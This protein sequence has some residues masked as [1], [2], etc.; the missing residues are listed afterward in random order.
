MW[1]W[2]ICNVQVEM[3]LQFFQLNHLLQLLI[4]LLF[5]WIAKFT[6]RLPYLCCQGKADS[7]AERDRR[8]G[9]GEDALERTA[10]GAVIQSFNLE[11]AILDHKSHAVAIS[12]SGYVCGLGSVFQGLFKDVRLGYFSALA[13][14]DCKSGEWC[15]SVNANGLKQIGEDVLWALI[16]LVMLMI[17]QFLSEKVVLYWASNS[18]ALMTSDNRALA[19]IEAGASS[20][21][22]AQHSTWHDMT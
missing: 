1:L 16:G 19:L 15:D 2:S 11:K 3:A 12:F 13:D 20:V 22:P 14:P 5:L 10:S 21:I 6:Y 18:R 8:L 4:A 9:G 17:T 7:N